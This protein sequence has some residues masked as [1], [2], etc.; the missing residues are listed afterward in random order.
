MKL[1]LQFDMDA[2]IIDV[3]QSVLDQK[4]TLSDKFLT[5]IY[6]KQSNHKYWVKMQ[7]DKK[8]GVQYRSDAFIEWLN[9]YF[10]KNSEEK[11]TLL[12]EHICD[13]PDDLPTLY[14]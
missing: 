2:D 7:G 9:R 11:A 13:Y 12:T 5:W 1:V 8:Y 4:D 14:F 3:P 10:L 6:N